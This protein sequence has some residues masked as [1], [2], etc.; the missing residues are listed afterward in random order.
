MPI[1]EIGLNAAAEDWRKGK[2]LVTQ[3][4]EL[5]NKAK[6]VFEDHTRVTGIDKWRWAELAIALIHVKETLAYPK[7]KLLEVFTE[8]QL[9]PASEIKLP[10]EYI[11][12][13][14]LRKEELE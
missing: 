8:E 10:Y 12:V 7:K 5:I 2:E 13:E 11:R 14:D 9:E 3:G 4:Q 6:E 1:E